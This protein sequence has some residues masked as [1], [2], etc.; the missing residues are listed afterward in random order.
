MLFYSGFTYCRKCS[1][2]RKRRYRQRRGEECCYCIYGRLLPGLRCF[3]WYR[4]RLFFHA[5]ME[6]MLRCAAAYIK[7][8][9]HRPPY[10][11]QRLRIMLCQDS[12]L[13]SPWNDILSL[14]TR[15]PSQGNEENSRRTH[16]FLIRNCRLSRPSCSYAME[17]LVFLIMTLS[18]LTQSDANDRRATSIPPCF[19]G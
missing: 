18:M 13:P 19:S 17:T 7:F 10:M 4:A 5:K 12:Y 6:P 1:T 2:E 16:L 3:I 15:S 9:T 14:C 8:G 11:N